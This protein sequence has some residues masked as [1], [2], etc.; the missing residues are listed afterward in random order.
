MELM[1]RVVRPCTR[2][3]LA[4]SLAGSVWGAHAQPGPTP[5]AATHQLDL[6]HTFVYWE[7]LHMGTSTVR[8]R[9]D[10]LSGH[11]VFNP[12]AKVLE[13]EIVVDATSVST[14]SQVFDNVLRGPNLLNA[15]D[16]P[17]A[18]FRALQATWDGLRPKAI[19]G[20]LSLSGV[21]RPLT[22]T[23][24]RWRCALNPLFRAEVCGGDLEATLPRG[25]FGLG[26][27]APW[28]SDEVKLRVQVEAVALPPAAAQTT[29]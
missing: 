22:L 15:V 1:R 26:F 13:V 5:Q 14:G 7:V 6:G 12:R 4:T 21:T 11:L 20:S 17:Q 9:F 28:V 24:M 18:V 16:H 27:G 23:V 8:G 25:E 29:E 19:T 2:V 10:R 3:L